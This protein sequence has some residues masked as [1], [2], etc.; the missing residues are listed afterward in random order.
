MPITKFDPNY[1][2]DYIIRTWVENRNQLDTEKANEEYPDGQ[3]SIVK[4][5]NAGGTRSSKTFDLIHVILTI[6]NNNKGRKIL[7]HVYRDTLVNA[8]DTTL[9]DFLRCFELIGLEL[10]VDFTA[11]GIKQGRPMIEIW[12]HI[13]EF[14]GM[15]ETAKQA[16][17]CDIAY[18]N[19]LLESDDED[20]VK[21][22]MQRCE[23]L[24]LADWN[25]S[26]TEHWAYHKQGQ[27]NT[28]YTLTTYLDNKHLPEGFQGDYESR[29]P[30]DFRDSHIEITDG[31]FKRRVWDK[32]ERPENMTQEDDIEGKYRRD[33]DVNKKNNT[34]DRAWWL[35]YGEGIPCSREG[36]V[37]HDV[38]WHKEFPESGF[39]QVHFGLDFGYSKDPSVLVRMG[40]MGEKDLYIEPLAY[41]TTPTPDILFDLIEP[42]ILKEIERR[43]SESE[44]YDIADV[45]IIC[46]SADKFKTGSNDF[47]F[48]TDL[49]YISMRKGLDWTFQKVKKPQVVPRVSAMK[50]CNI[51][52]VEGKNDRIAKEFHVEQQNYVYDSGTNIPVGKYNHIWDASG[53][54]F[55]G[56]IRH[57]L[58]IFDEKD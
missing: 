56:L 23:K 32:P 13:I 46:D 53:Y 17:R 50:R 52:C 51:H 1:L 28:F 3:K 47:Q 33:N 38:Q 20:I 43:K 5:Y 41:Q 42:Q 22:I 54:C 58:N 11:V 39:S 2:H 16:G 55:W 19:E 36:A 15:P 6:L 35:T 25:P 7:V 37:F 8:R 27:F 10:D 45:I 29:C 12:G 30:W 48:V 34:I 18:I 14:R 26:K 21:G 40:L 24:F 44:G 4:I 31:G 9:P 57:L 49:N